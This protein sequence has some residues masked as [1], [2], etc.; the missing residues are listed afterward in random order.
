[1]SF[2][3]ELLQ[4]IKQTG[5][6]LPGL[7]SPYEHARRLRRATYYGALTRLEQRGLIEKKRNKNRIV[8]VPTEKGRKFNISK[9]VMQKRRTDGFST[10]VMFDI[11]ETKKRERGILR[12]C[13]LGNKYTMLQKSVFISPNE[14]SSDL[15]ELIK[16]LGVRPNI[17]VLTSK[18]FYF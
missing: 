9:K 13:L 1:M 7:E 14:F 10:V 6:L 5:E 4:F 2:T 12:R 17:S 15:K 8:Y 3:N 11:P 18:V 16:E